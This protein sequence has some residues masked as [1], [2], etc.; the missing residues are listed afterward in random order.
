[1][2]IFRAFLGRG[3]KV[4]EHDIQVLEADKKALSDMLNKH[5][6]ELATLRQ[7][8]I[9]ALR[10]VSVAEQR[11]EKAELEIAHFFNRAHAAEDKLAELS[12]PHPEPVRRK[13]GRPKKVKQ[14]A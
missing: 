12:K 7:R 10:R 2:S 1:M 5:R 3:K 9:D 13:V 6:D 11:A 14:N 4:T 8:F